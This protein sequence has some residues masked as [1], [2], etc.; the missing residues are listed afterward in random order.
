MTKPFYCQLQQFLDEG[1]T[2]AVATIVQVKGSTPREVGAKM[3]IHPY[4]KHVGPVGGGRRGALVQFGQ[5]G[6]QQLTGAIGVHVRFLSVGGSAQQIP[7]SPAL[8]PPT[9]PSNPLRPRQ[10]PG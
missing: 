1:L 5:L 9:Q 7:A 6:G 3:I 4:G 10:L 2:V 8:E